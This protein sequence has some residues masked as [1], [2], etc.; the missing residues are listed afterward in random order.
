MKLSSIL[1]KKSKTT[2]KN[3]CGSNMIFL[4]LFSILCLTA[5]DFFS[6]PTKLVPHGGNKKKI[7]GWSQRCSVQMCILL[8]CYTSVSKHVFIT[9][10]TVIC[11]SVGSINSAWQVYRN[12]ELW[13]QK[14]QYTGSSPIQSLVIY[15]FY[16]SAEWSGT[17]LL[18][19]HM[20]VIS[21]QVE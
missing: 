6:H 4:F 10:A 5:F 1:E 14:V 18:Y 12:W 21:L 8:V 11:K 15:T 2:N 7:S 17:S 13:N 20:S 9:H 3:L 16:S 19:L